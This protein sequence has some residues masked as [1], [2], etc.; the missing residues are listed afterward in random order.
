MS[1]PNVRMRR[2][3]RTEAMRT[4]LNQIRIQPSNLIYPVFVDEAL[5]EPEHITAMPGYFRC[6]LDQVI[7]EGQTA[8]EQGIKSILLFGIPAEKNESG[9][10]AYAKD[11]IIQ[12]ATRKLKDHF[13]DELIIMADVCLCEYINHGHCGIIKDGDIQNDKTLELLGKTAVSQ[14]AAGVDIVAPS[15]MMDGQ[16]GA[17]REALDEADFDQTAIL[18][19]SAK[20]ASSFF[21]PFREAADS[22]PRF[23]NRKTYQMNPGGVKEALRE[24]ELDINE[25]AD[26]VMVKPALAYLDILSLAKTTFDVPIVAYNTSGEYSL[27]R[28]AALNGWVDEQAVIHEILTSIKRAGAD[29]IITYHAKNV[30]A[31]LNYT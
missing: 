13:K 4:M 6:P 17:I 3:R 22:A 10:G 7:Q 8:L 23:G 24:I 1:F 29:M 21:G 12:Q 9:S 19:Y 5:S 25:G 15:A 16:V 28:A 26:M 18:A 2:L 20:Y 11:G 14:A 27:V 31:W 30:N